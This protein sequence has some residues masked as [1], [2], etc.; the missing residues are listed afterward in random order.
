[1]WI[2]CRLLGAASNCPTAG[3]TNMEKELGCTE[4]KLY[5]TTWIMITY[6]HTHKPY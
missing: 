4:T 1:M 3:L 5:F 6:H 2:G